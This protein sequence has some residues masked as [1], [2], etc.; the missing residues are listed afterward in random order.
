M[1]IETIRYATA[2]ENY[3]GQRSNILTNDLRK[4]VLIKLVRDST[5]GQGKLPSV[6]SKPLLKSII[7]TLQ[8]ISFQKTLFS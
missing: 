6:T 7:K 4:K 5:R 3:D 2:C 8:C 1:V